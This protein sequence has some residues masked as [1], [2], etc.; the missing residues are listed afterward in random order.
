[1]VKDFGVAEISFVIISKKPVFVKR[2]LRFFQRNFG[3]TPIEV[4]L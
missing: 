1:M 2:N 3:N 4:I